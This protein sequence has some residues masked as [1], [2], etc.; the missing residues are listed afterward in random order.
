MT[1]K[2]GVVMDP[3]AD[4]TYK[5]DTT[6]ALLDAAQQRGCEL[7][8]MEQS[9]LSIQNGRA[10]ARMAPLNVRMNPEDWFDLGEYQELPLGELDIVL[11]RKDPPF[12]G[13]FIYSTYILERAAEEGALIANNPQSL[14]DCNEKVFATAFPQFMTPTIVT[15]RADLLKAFHQEHGDVIFKP[16]DGMGGSSI[17]RI[18][19]DDAN[20][21]VIIETLTD[22]GKQ[23][24]MAQRFIPEITAG[25]KRILMIDGEPVPYCLARIPAQGETRGNLAAG[26]AGVTQPLSDENRAIAEKIGPIL[27]EKGLY[28]VGLDIIG[29]NLTE[30]NVT[31]PTCVREISRDSG[32]DVAGQ[33][34]DCL[35]SKLS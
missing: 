26:G 13:E 23:Q 28:F 11:M 20:I 14:R 25:D 24:I 21:N 22:F 34:I 1:V 8:Y 12:D 9:D 16:L 33:L 10:M 5:K 32:I 31:S 7:W 17:F 6:L 2:L 19:P 29:N 4:I 3:I 27:K 30:I 15:R 35:L 18:K